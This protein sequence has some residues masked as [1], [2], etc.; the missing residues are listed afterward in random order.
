MLLLHLWVELWGSIPLGIHSH[1]S[2]KP[3][4]GRLEVAMSRVLLI[5]SAPFR[6]NEIQNAAS[7]PGPKKQHDGPVRLFAFSPIRES[8]ISRAVTS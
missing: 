7:I 2:L 1:V 5:S 8:Q 6:N 3:D 4:E